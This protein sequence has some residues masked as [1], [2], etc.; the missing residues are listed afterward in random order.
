MSETEDR[1]FRVTWRSTPS[2]GSGTSCEI[3]E[4][5]MV[6]AAYYR[7]DDDRM[8]FKR[9]DGRQVFDVAAA[10]VETIENLDDVKAAA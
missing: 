10:L 8:V 3:L 6:I 2:I 5:R 7:R 1:T 9:A 4:E